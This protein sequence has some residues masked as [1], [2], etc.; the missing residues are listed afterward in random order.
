MSK[1]AKPKAKKSLSTTAIITIVVA[2][3][4]CFG[5]VAAALISG[6]FLYVTTQ[7][8][9][10]RP[11]AFTQTAE[12]IPP[13]SSNSFDWGNILTIDPQTP[14]PA[15]YVPNSMYQ[16]EDK[17]SWVKDNLFSYYTNDELMYAP[18]L[19]YDL[20]GSLKLY[21][22]IT[23]VETD[24]EWIVLSKDLDVSV[25][26][27]DTEPD[28]AEIVYLTGCGGE[29][30]Y[31]DFSVVPLNA[32]YPEYL[33]SAE[34]NDADYY[35][36]EPGESEMFVLNFQCEATGVYSV[37]VELPVKY[38]GEDKTVVY[39]SFPGILCPDHLNFN[40][41]NPGAP[42]GDYGY[43]VV[44]YNTEQYEWNGTGYTET[45]P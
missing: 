37:K 44:L 41:G 4:G 25:R 13:Q 32:D 45:G 9:I 3:L 19:A 16:G 11:I 10:D 21:L 38:Q 6:V 15:V 30:F 5:T 2:F 29:G 14:C 18:L 17:T 36:L 28:M 43:E 24:G 33:T 34:S 23:N 22:F 7:A 40:Y 35:T 39:T 42:I 12:Y 20:S 1:S 31:R 8:Q 26:H 27:V